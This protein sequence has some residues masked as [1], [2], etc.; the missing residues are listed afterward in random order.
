MMKQIEAKSARN[1]VYIIIDNVA[2][3]VTDLQTSKPGKHGHLKCKITAKGILDGKR[4][5][6]E[7]PGSAKLDSPI[8]E[9]KV[10]QVISI[11]GEIAQVMDIES[12]ETFESRIPEDLKGKLIEGGNVVYWIIGETKALMEIKS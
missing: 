5:V 2:C 7:K 11:Q 8:I 9:K 12:Y 1:G 10:A 4:R 6:I 3:K